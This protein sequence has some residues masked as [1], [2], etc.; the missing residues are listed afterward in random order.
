[1]WSMMKKNLSLKPESEKLKQLSTEQLIEIII[2]QATVIG[3]IGQLKARVLELEQEIK[4]LKVSRDSDSTT[5]SKPPSG[6]ILKKLRT[7]KKSLKDQNGN[8]EDSQDIPVKQEK[9][10]GE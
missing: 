10:L 2:E 6:D 3:Q 1:M 8:Q 9:G 5:S 7:D 4:K